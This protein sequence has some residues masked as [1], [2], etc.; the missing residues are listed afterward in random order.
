M[1]AW[2]R[3]G[4]AGACL[5]MFGALAFAQ[6]EEP[7]GDAEAT[8]EAASVETPV[9]RLKAILV[10]MRKAELEALVGT[11]LDQ[12]QTV[13]EALNDVT[14][15]DEKARLL[16]QRDRIAARFDAVIAACEAK[17]G[18]VT[19]ARAYLAAGSGDVIAGFGESIKE[20]SVLLV[21]LREWVMSPEGGIDWAKRIG[22]FIVVMIAFKIV[23]KILGGITRKGVSRLRKT[24]ELLRDFFVNTVM[25]LT[26]FIGL[27][28]GL[29]ILGV[30]IGP[31][32]AAIGAIG[33]IIAFALQGTLSNFASGIMIL[34]YRPYDI[35]D[36]VDVA[37]VTGKVSAMSLVSTTVLTPDNQ[38]SVIPNNSIWGG[39]ITNVTGSPTRRV[40]LMFG[41]GY[42]DDI[43]KAQ[44]VIESVLEA[45]ELIL[46]D[47]EPVVKV[48][49][50]GDSSVNFVVRPWS[51]TADY[52]T[53]YWDVTRQVK[54]RFDE[55]GISIPFPQRDV[56]VHYGTVADS[57]A[58]SEA[59]PNAA[60]T[61]LGASEAPQHDAAA[62]Y[63]EGADEDDD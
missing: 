34:M 56:H 6:D 20:P 26:F 51:R 21:R 39:I 3:L 63:M 49:S 24:S 27:V 7:A 17:G 8:P 4:V 38:V 50:L 62:R 53:V 15:A 25:K 23:G 46:K 35:G 43:P 44:Q 58:A 60:P 1:N 5:L 33:F 28:I 29:G 36:F 19:E 37:G 16:G 47:P 14:D 40:D 57:E 10:P 22:L 32:L 45:H 11:W 18:D 9:A 31:F 30:N 12:L 2:K 13:L 42:D 55:E 41:I 52:W 48:H 61:E 59:A 54:M